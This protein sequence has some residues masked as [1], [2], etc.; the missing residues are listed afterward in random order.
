[1]H[2]P[3]E[4]NASN[5]I[6]QHQQSGLHQDPHVPA[7]LFL[8]PSQSPC[9]PAKAYIQEAS[10]S[11]RD[12]V[13]LFS[14]PPMQ[15][16]QN[17]AEFWLAVPNPKLSAGAVQMHGDTKSSYIGFPTVNDIHA[18]L[19]AAFCVMTVSCFL[20]FTHEQLQQ[21]IRQLCTYANAGPAVHVTYILGNSI[22]SFSLAVHSCSWYF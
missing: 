13:Y 5:R 15:H 18:A 14:I 11:P 7:L 9:T 17:T 16:P 4:R 8:F 22:Y 12:R 2:P 20:S 21:E 19:C 6:A 10:S 1:M 3:R